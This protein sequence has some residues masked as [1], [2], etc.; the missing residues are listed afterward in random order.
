MILGYNLLISKK[1]SSIIDTFNYLFIKSI[2]ICNLI[3][4]YLH[5]PNDYLL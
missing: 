1:K 2:T 5:K 3:K 4:I